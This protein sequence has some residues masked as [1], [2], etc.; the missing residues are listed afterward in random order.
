[1]EKFAIG[2]PQKYQSLGKTIFQNSNAIF[3][4]SLLRVIQ[5]HG[6]WEIS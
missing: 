1:M 2:F 6:R 4:N 5:I 3:L